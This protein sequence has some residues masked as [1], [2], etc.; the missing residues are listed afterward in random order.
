MSRF[1]GI[2]LPFLT[3]L[4]LLNPADARALRVCDGPTVDALYQSL[5]DILPAEDKP[6]LET[7][8]E[9]WE[10]FAYADGCRVED[11]FWRGT[12]SM[13][14]VDRQYRR[15]CQ[16]RCDFLEGLITKYRKNVPAFRREN[17]ILCSDDEMTPEFNTFVYDQKFGEHSKNEI[18]KVVHKEFGIQMVKANRKYSDRYAEIKE[19]CTNHYSGKLDK[20]RYETMTEHLEAS[21][22]AW[23]ASVK[24]DIQ[25]EQRTSRGP[26]GQVDVHL[27]LLNLMIE[28][29]RTF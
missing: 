21:R 20:D 10:E 17:N 14:A 5:M 3:C 24:A 4:L 27:Q 25:L 22:E 9:L 7:S 8:Q 26:W 19:I 12:A 23:D 2:L 18:F 6:Y 1:P 11:N 16:G 15:L 29:I 28:R 13:T